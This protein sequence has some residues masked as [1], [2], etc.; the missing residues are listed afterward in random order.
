MLLIDILTK[1]IAAPI[2]GM[3]SDKYGRKIVLQVGIALVGVSMIGMG[4]S[5]NI[6][7]EY[8]LARVIIE[9]RI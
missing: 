9:S 2:V 1:C 3:L 5:Q 4:Y 8:C 7:P 6:Y